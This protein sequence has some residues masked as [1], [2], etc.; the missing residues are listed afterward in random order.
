MA[1][2][3][4]LDAPSAKPRRAALA[5]L[6]D[7]LVRMVG[8]VPAN[9]RTKLLVAFLA[10]A[11]LLVLVT[12]LGLHVLGQSNARVERLRALQLRS[13]QYQTLEAS[14]GD[15]QQTLTVRAAGIPGLTNYTGGARLQGGRLWTLADR[16]IANLL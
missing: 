8:G 15:L 11:G 7:R 2:P 1:H 10:I 5:G 13:A 14:A 4:V 16:E 12:V 9:L 3:E 6:R